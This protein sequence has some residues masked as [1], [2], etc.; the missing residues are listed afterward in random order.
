MRAR[1]ARQAAGVLGPADPNTRR[2]PTLPAPPRRSLPCMPPS[3]CCSKMVRQSAVRMFSTLVRSQAAGEASAL[4]GGSRGLLAGANV[5]AGCF[6]ALP[7]CADRRLPCRCSRP[8]SANPHQPP[9]LRPPTHAAR[10]PSAGRQQGLDLPLRPRGVHGQPRLAAGA[11]AARP[12][13]PP[14]GPRPGARVPA[15]GQPGALG[16]PAR[17]VRQ[18]A[19]VGGCDR[20]VFAA[21]FGSAWM[22]WGTGAQA[23]RRSRCASLRLTSPRASVPTHPAALCEQQAPRRP[24]HAQPGPRQG[25]RRWS[26]ALR[27]LPV[28]RRLARAR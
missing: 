2:P 16:G 23:C 24:P 20:K 11:L 14:L 10:A 5:S 28:V 15:P 6:L 12:P 9:S 1:P 17:W 22:A 19:G 26:E 21:G 13:Q 3:H 27:R 8:A 18:W 25:H 7:A 4:M